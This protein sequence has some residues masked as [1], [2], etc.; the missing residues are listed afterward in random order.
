M[1]AQTSGTQFGPSEEFE[2]ETINKGKSIITEHVQ[3]NTSAQR[4]LKS[5][6]GSLLSVWLSAF[7]A[8]AL[9]ILT[10]VY[11]GNSSL[12]AGHRSFGRSPSN[13]LLVLRVLS[14]LAGVMLATTIAGTLE[15]L[16]WMLISREGGKKGMSFTD[17][18]VMNAGTGVPGLLRLA[19]GRGIPKL[20]SRFWSMARLIG[21]AMVPLLN[22]VIMSD[23]STAI[24]YDKLTDKAPVYG[25]GIGIFNASLAAIWHPMADMMFST[26]FM[27]FLA[28]GARVVDITAPDA[29]KRCNSGEDGCEA[30]YFVSGGSGDFAPA[31]LASGGSRGADA[32][33]A[34]SQ[35]GFV[36]DYTD[37]KHDWQF[38]DSDCSVFGADIAAWGLC[39]KDGEAENE[40]RARLIDCP[41]DVASMFK[42]QTTRSWLRN[43]GFSSS[44]HSWYRSAEVAYSRVN[45]SILTHSFDD[46]TP[47]S[48]AR[49]PA[50][51]LLKAF[52]LVFKSSNQASP[53]ANALTLLGVGNNTAATPIYAWWY[54][55]G[56]SRLAA[57]D[58]AAKRRG[59][60]GLQS[61]LGLAIYHCQPKAFGE[62]RDLGYDNTTSV[63]KAILAS[64]PTNVQG[65]P[66]FPAALRYIIV[67]DRGT[68]VAYI[69]LGG[70]TL[71]LC[72]AALV[73]VTFV[74]PINRERGSSSFPILDFL[75]E[76]KVVHEGH[77][78]RR[79]VM[80]LDAFKD[81]NGERNEKETLDRNTR[82][83]R[84]ILTERTSRLRT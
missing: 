30:S 24:T 47:R 20:S 51:E 41:A 65:T 28:D 34:E 69:V 32:F 67:I 12:L 4:E 82:G 18:L 83:L 63:G 59:I 42:C 76:C 43:P 25:Y 10:S 17:Y 7:L 64:F 2:L 62:I 11:A 36:F 1:L 6:D 50:S 71:I 13:V 72:F 21:I 22:V 37:G 16:Q 44:L 56:A 48:P 45:D 35:P 31:L 53:F 9:L 78:T 57:T 46:S 66:V 79:S 60:S 38:S 52:I 14:E 3:E 74:S 84:V 70:S 33:L 61:M 49:I 5:F 73:A 8:L 75:S 77:N 23:V 54:F 39:L 68:L 81:R 58:P 40:I 29:R 15:V 55:H 26:N 80:S 19:F 27:Y